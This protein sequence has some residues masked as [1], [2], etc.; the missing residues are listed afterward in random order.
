M[1]DMVLKMG[2]NSCWRVV[3]MSCAGRG[4]PLHRSR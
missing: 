1:D 4:L 2:S 3:F